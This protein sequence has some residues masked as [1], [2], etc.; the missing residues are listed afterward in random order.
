MAETPRAGS[1]QR[2]TRQGEGQ[3]GLGTVHPGVTLIANDSFC[4]HWRTRAHTLPT[5]GPSSLPHH[6]VPAPP[7]FPQHLGP[8]RPPHCGAGPGLRAEPSG[9][10]EESRPLPEERLPQNRAGGQDPDRGRTALPSPW[11][12]LPAPLQSEGFKEP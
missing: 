2:G 4:C 8:R 9:C 12:P 5:P 1:P 3:A 10:G 11:V 7:H 6:P